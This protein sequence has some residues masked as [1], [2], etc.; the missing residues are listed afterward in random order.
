MADCRRDLVGHCGGHGGC[1]G[2]VVMAEVGKTKQSGLSGDEWESI[3]RATKDKAPTDQDRSDLNSEWM[4]Q[5][6]V[7]QPQVLW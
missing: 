5:F 2:L 7:Q 3:L 6:G 1:E 4:R